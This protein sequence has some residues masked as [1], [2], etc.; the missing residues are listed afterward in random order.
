MKNGK[1]ALAYT[2]GIIDGEGCINIVRHKNNTKRGFSFQLSVLVRNTKEWLCQWL[3]MQYGGTITYHQAEK[4]FSNTWLWVLQSNKAL[5]M[6]KLIVPYL[7]L[8]RP[9]A[10]LAILFHENYH[11]RPKTNDEVAVMEAQLIL[12]SKMKKSN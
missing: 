6:I 9:E 3:K 11:K 10:E 1:V 8:K 5:D 2:A 7:N 4:P 12:M